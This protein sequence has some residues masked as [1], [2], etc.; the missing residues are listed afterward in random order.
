MAGMERCGI[1]GNLSAKGRLNFIL[2][3]VSIGLEH[4]VSTNILLVLRDSFRLKV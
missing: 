4:H 3:G 1:R 2:R